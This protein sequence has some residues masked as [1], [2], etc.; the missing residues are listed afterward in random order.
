MIPLSGL[1]GGLLASIA[2][3]SFALF[4]ATVAFGIV[5]L[6]GVDDQKGTVPGLTVLITYVLAVA[7]LAVLVLYVAHAGERLRASG[8]IDLV[9]D[10]LHV[11]IGR[12]FPAGDRRPPVP[13]D[14]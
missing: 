1:V 2:V 12:R 13:P 5:A 9:G 11:Q 7:S 6:H 10:E 4:G 8:L 14:V 3:L